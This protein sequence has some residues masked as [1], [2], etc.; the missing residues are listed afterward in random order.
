MHINQAASA[1]AIQSRIKNAIEFTQQ[2][3]GIF[4]QAIQK[5]ITAGTAP[6][7]SAE[8]SAVTR[9]SEGEDIDWGL[10]SANLG[11]ANGNIIYTTDTLEIANLALE[12]AQSKLDTAFA[13]AGIS[14]A[15]PVEFTLSRLDGSLEV[16]DHP[17]KD[18]IEALLANNPE[19]KEDVRTAFVLKEQAIYTE[20]G[21]I[22]A[23]AYHRIYASK[24]KEAADA[25][26]DKFLSLKQVVPTFRYGQAGIDT[27]YEGK[28]AQDYLASIAAIL[29]FSGVSLSA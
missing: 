20:K 7:Q 23:E 4:Q 29:N 17:A 16:K 19:L 27:L 11:A 9:S 14:N 8:N 3:K 26:A 18:N 6:S 22:Y 15:P 1:F 10:V 21:S 13:L 25:L 12:D 24:G 5:N 28:N 2:G